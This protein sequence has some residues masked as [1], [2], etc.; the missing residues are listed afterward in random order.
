VPGRPHAGGAPALLAS[1][2]FSHLVG[3]GLSHAT[4]TGKV[5]APCGN[6]HAVKAGSAVE[7]ALPRVHA[8]YSRAA[9]SVGRTE[10]ARGAAEGQGVAGSLLPR[11]GVRGRVP[12][13]ELAGLASAGRALIAHE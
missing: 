8:R 7:G 9:L 11:A 5:R 12:R 2:L 10:W 13:K 1:G 4:L 6:A 3:A